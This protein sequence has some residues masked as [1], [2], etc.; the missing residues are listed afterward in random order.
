[1]RAYIISL[2]VAIDK[3]RQQHHFIHPVIPLKETLRH[4]Q[5][6][7]MVIVAQVEERNVLSQLKGGG[8][9]GWRIDSNNGHL[10]TFEYPIHMCNF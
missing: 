1:M 10:R 2:V 4:T 8:D 6:D 9:R 5:G 3:E 7:K